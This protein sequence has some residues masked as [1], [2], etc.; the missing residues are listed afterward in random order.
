MKLIIKTI[1]LL[2]FCIGFL[3]IVIIVLYGYRDIPLEDLKAKYARA[4]SSFISVDGMNV[5]F[6]DE[7]DRKN[8]IPIV[9]I[10]GT[11]SSLHTFNDWTI[12]LKQ[13][14]RVVRMDLPGY[15]LT[16]PFP[17]RSY[18]ID[19]YVDFLKHFLTS[20]GVKKCVIGGNSLGGGIA[21]SF[22][23][24]YPEMV[25]K[26]ILI[27]ASGYPSKAKSVPVAFKIAKIPVVKNIFTF[28]TPRFVA[29]SS[30]ENVFADKTKVTDKLI[31][32]YFELT[33][34]EG[35]RQAFIDKL[36]RKKNTITYK[37][38]K[39]I[40]QRTL[41]LWGDQD[42]LIPVDKAYQFHNDLPND[43]L[44]IMKDVG[45]VPMEESPSLSAEAVITFLKNK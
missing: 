10:H 11:G 17:D 12:Q 14:F 25:D 19:N 40:K 2:F 9:L 31:D 44:F 22:T 36:E 29:K 16:G 28:I 5:H 23:S 7:G 1:K 21:W 34:R 26:L 13:D 30:L 3:T 24:K 41:V 32:R 15:G 43:T 35:N 8:S 18:S 37:S 38:I 33:L 27:N 6:R 45:H 39:L 4:P 42:K 20:L